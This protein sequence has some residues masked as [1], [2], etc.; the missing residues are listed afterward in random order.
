MLK[1]KVLGE[2]AKKISK[3]PS[4]D[5]YFEV[6]W[7]I[8]KE[9]YSNKREIISVYFSNTLEA[10]PVF[11][12]SKRRIN[13][14]LQALDAMKLDPED[15]QKAFLCFVLQRKIDEHLRIQFDQHLGK[16]R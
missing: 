10:H 16:S 11:Y 15:M 5:E 6:A 13:E 3:L 7:G 2:A 8:L 9:Y 14:S 1:A 12:N 4:K